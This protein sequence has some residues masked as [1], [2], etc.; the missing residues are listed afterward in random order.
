MAIY[1]IFASAD[2]TLYSRYP[3][4]NT[5]RDS[6]LEISAKNSQDG[7]RFLYRDKLTDNPYYTYDLAA[8]SNYDVSGE[9]FP[10]KDIRR[11]VLQ[12]SPEDIAKIYTLAS[13]SSMP[14]IAATLTISS[15]Y[16]DGAFF[17][18]SGSIS[19][20]F[21]V[22]SSTTQVDSAPV[23]YIV[24][25]STADLTAVA[26]ANKVS[27]L[28]AFN[29]TA[30][31]SAS[32]IYLTSS[33][34]GVVGNTFRYSS[35]SVTQL[36]SGGVD[37]RIASS[38]ASLKLFL[39]SAQN[40]STTYSLESYAITQ[41]WSMGTGQYINVPESR[42]GVS[43]TYTGPYQNSPLWTVTGSSYD[44]NY[45]ASQSFNYMSDKDVSM[46]VTKIVNGWFSSSLGQGGVTPY[47]LVV[48]HPDVI[49]NTTSSFVDLKFFSVDTHTIYP[50][51]IEFKWADANYYPAPGSTNYVLNDQITITLANNQG[52]FRQNQV[53]KV[54]T[55][56]RYTYP[57][58]NFTT[59]SAYLSALYLPENAYW[60]LQDVKTQ[61][62]VVNFD[63]NYTKLS[64]DSIG[65][66]F[67]LYTSGLE[68]NRFYRILIKAHI[69]STTYGPLSV[70]DND[71]SIYDALSF[72]GPADLALLP[73]EEVIY[74]GP[75]LIFKVVQ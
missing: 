67:T 58:R 41:P 39:A 72:Y 47:G 46:D 2:A 61:E 33:L 21:F 17:Q 57:P 19:G 60:A 25:G 6:I 16:Q 24:T 14:A 40:L 1:N 30:S 55:S 12:F 18:L 63:E 9:F 52:Q 75:N 56:V 20:T 53:Y 8:N 45:A 26:I 5:G 15:S 29:I 71:Q 11:A 31:V 38:Q 49:E 74:T 28:A 50:P 65:N 27:G 23:Y 36:F 73:A 7:V 10:Q 51:T 70:Y 37:A 54:R 13:Q 44:V 66:Y 48:K 43:W 32:T 42:N 3:A 59:Q 64:A 4:K 69:Y 62:T 68:V 35:G 34:G 22:T